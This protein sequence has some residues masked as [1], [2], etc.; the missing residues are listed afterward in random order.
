MYYHFSAYEVPESHVQS[1]SL[2]DERPAFGALAL[3]TLATRSLVFCFVEGT[4]GSVTSQ[5]AVKMGID[6][7]RDRSLQRSESAAEIVQGGFREANRRVYDYGA[8]MLA[9]AKIAARGFLLGFD[10]K[11]ISV[12]RTGDYESF[13]LRDERLMRFYVPGRMRTGGDMARFLGSGKQIMVDLANV[14]PLPGDWVVLTSLPWSVEF[15]EIVRDVL[16]RG[17]DTEDVCAEIGFRS[18]GLFRGQLEENIVV[19]A[20]LI[21]G[22]S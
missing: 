17:E 13:L 18:L 16:L 12:G 15:E 9:G 5:I 21:G 3:S 7:M 4:R 22:R 19:G 8:K 20:L 10:G 11:Q 14:A 6:A 2:K 1:L